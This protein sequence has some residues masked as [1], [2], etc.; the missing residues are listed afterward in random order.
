MDHHGKLDY[1]EAFLYSREQT[2][3]S[4]LVF[5]WT[6]SLVKECCDSILGRRSTAIRSEKVVILFPSFAIP[7]TVAV[8]RLMRLLIL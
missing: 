2:E 6:K 5:S 4:C 8:R 1:D 3:P 7:V